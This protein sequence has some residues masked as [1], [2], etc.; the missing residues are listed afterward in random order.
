MS[1]MVKDREDY[2]VEYQIN[3]FLELIPEKDREEIKQKYFTDPK[4]YAISFD[5]DWV[6]NKDNEGFDV[7]NALSNIGFELIDT[8]Y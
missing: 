8:D 4:W 7:R 1:R 6:W 2:E 3:E 5:R